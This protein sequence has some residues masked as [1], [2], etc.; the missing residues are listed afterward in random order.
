MI[1]IRV[2]CCSCREDVDHIVLT[3]AQL[4]I[5]AQL[6]CVADLALGLHEAVDNYFE[7]F[8]QAPTASATSVALSVATS[9]VASTS[10]SVSVQ[11]SQASQASQSPHYDNGAHNRYPNPFLTAMTGDVSYE[12]YKGDGSVDAGWPDQTD[13]I[14]FRNM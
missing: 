11:S 3:I 2:C 12:A 9:A 1:S 4:A 6:A 10:A 13:W 14:D 7:E 8:I 5:L